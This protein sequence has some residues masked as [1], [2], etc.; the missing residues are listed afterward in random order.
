VPGGEFGMK[1]TINNIEIYIFFSRNRN[2][3]T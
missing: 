3:E 1:R 2:V